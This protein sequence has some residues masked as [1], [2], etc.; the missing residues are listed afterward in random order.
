MNNRLVEV[1]KALR[2]SQAAFA[3]KTGL[4]RSY[5]WK[6]ENGE[7]T[8]SDRA[9]RDICRTFNVSYEWL[10]TGE[11][12]MFEDVSSTAID[13]LAAAYQL[14]EQDK[15]IITSFLSLD[16]KERAAIIKFVK[17]MSN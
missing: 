7:R 12:E 9:V 10:T 14:E 17:N 6:V 4:T 15:K 8:L 11:G 16:S 1:R 2:L 5:V 3:E 13:A